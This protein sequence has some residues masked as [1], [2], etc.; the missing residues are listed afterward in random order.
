LVSPVKRL[1]TCRLWGLPQVIKCSTIDDSRNP[2]FGEKNRRFVGI[3]PSTTKKKFEDGNKITIYESLSIPEEYDSLVVSKA[4][5]NRARH[6]IKILV[7][8]L[9]LHSKGLKPKKQFGVFMPFIIKEAIR[10]SIS[11]TDD[12]PWSMT[13]MNRLVRYIAVI[14][15]EKMDFRPRLV[16][17][18][19]GQFYPIATFED[20]AEALQLMKVVTSGM[21]QYL[22]K[23]YNKRFLISYRKLNNKPNQVT[24]VT[25]SG[26]EYDIIEDR[27]GLSTQQ[28]IEDIKNSGESSITSDELRKKYLYPLFNHG[29][30]D[31]VHSKINSRESIYFPVREE[32][33]HSIF[34]DDN[35]PRL[36]IKNSENWPT[37]EIIEQSLV[38]PFGSCGFDVGQNYELFFRKEKVS[39]KFVSMLDVFS[40]PEICFKRELFGHGKNGDSDGKNSPTDSKKG[41]QKPKMTCQQGKIGLLMLKIPILQVMKKMD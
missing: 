38:K 19:T 14:T 35:D 25:K 2:R 41:V 33:I 30:I 24:R 27:A 4:D 22:M 31:S 28:I 10:Y 7:A 26:K 17:K 23:W 37:P 32:E 20:V 12:D 34:D 5:R 18:Q 39:A 29:L 36:T 15:L 8:K 9:K 13:V 16:N 3:S 6:T 1:E 11:S 21:R 40:N